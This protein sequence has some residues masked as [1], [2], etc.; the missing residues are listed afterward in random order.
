MRTKRVTYS[1]WWMA[2]IFV[3]TASCFVASAFPA[4]PDQ[5]ASIAAQTNWPFPAERSISESVVL[6]GHTLKYSVTIEAM[7][8]VNS[9]GQRTAGV[10]VTSYTVPSKTPR[11]VAFVFNGGPG[12]SSGFLNFG[13]IGPKHVQFGGKGDSPSDEIEPVDNQNTWLEFSDLVFIDPVGTGFSKSLL[14]NEETRKAF[15][16]IDQDAKYLA[17]VIYDWTK[18]HNRMT[19]RKY[20]IG[21]SYGGFRVPRIANEL[22]LSDNIGPS[23]LILISP[24]LDGHLLSPTGS[25][26][27]GV[28]PMAALLRLPSMAAANLEAQGIALSPARMKEVE[29]YARGEFVSSWLRGWSD[30][31]ALAVMVHRLAAFTGLPESDI[32]QR[33]GRIDQDF[34]LRERFR[35]QGLIASRYDIDVTSPDPDPWALSDVP[36]D[37]V[38][39]T[40]TTVG[41]A[42]TDFTARTM[43]WNVDAKYWAYNPAVYPGW[44]DQGIDPESVTALRSAM[45]LD[46]KMKVLIAHGYTD[47][48]CPYFGSKLIVDQIPP[49]LAAARLSLRIY[50]GGHMFYSRNDSAAAFKAN[51]RA[52]FE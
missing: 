30:P 23:G 52:L 5:R 18:L 14:P 45:A 19:A 26:N 35:L 28:S 41:S 39:T 10:V 43:G 22:Q 32:A 29:D 25:E 2:L 6:S 12:S 27:G 36:T 44:Y 51:A 1:R 15:W 3:A 21:E 7:P 37:S 9:S 49:S 11:P 40:F 47:L 8:V 4:S 46:P 38:V 20:L 13:A 31:T 42:L 17:R 24:Y 16:G 34:F 50:P 33:G 48:S